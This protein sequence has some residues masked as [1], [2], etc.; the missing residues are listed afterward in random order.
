MAFLARLRIEFHPHG[1]AVALA[2]KQI[3]NA[4]GVFLGSAAA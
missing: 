1:Q 3:L 2:M 4:S